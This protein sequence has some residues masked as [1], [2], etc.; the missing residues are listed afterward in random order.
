[1]GMYVGIMF[2]SIYI[3]QHGDELNFF[4]VSMITTVVL[5]AVGMFITSRP[6]KDPQ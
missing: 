4:D 3:S 1:M 6:P 2:L 5:I